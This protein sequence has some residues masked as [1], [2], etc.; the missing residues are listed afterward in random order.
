MVALPE[1]DAGVSFWWGGGGVDDDGDVPVEGK[2]LFMDEEVVAG[3]EDA[4]A[5]VGVVPAEDA[6]AGV[7]TIF[8][9]IALALSFVGEGQV[10]G[11]AFGLERGNLVADINVALSVVGVEAADEEAPH[12]EA[13]T[14]DGPGA[15]IGEGVLVDVDGH[16]RCRL[17]NGGDEGFRA[18]TRGE[19]FACFGGSSAFDFD[20]D[21]APFSLRFEVTTPGWVGPV[22]S[23]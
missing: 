3:E 9:L 19:F 12:F 16:G 11:G 18:E 1:E 6:F 14:F 15:H 5:G 10:S 2:E 23:L 8:D 13:P 7:I 17:A 4:V 22:I 21:H 20:L